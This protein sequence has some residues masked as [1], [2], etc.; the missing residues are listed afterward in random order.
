M[1]FATDRPTYRIPLHKSGPAGI[2]DIHGHPITIAV[3]GAL[4]LEVGIFSGDFVAAPSETNVV[5]TIHHVD[6]DGTVGAQLDSVSAAISSTTEA[7]WRRGTGHATVDFT[8][9]S[10]PKTA[11]SGGG[12]ARITLA[13]DAVVYVRDVV[14][15]VDVGSSILT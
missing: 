3:G 8:G 11:Y 10:W 9:S 1:S 7:A 4:R 2:R 6:A 12:F 13:L 5:V 14:S 15:I